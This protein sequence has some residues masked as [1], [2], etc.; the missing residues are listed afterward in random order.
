MDVVVLEGDLVVRA[1]QLDSPVMVRVATR[2]IFGSSVNVIVGQGD[3]VTG[4]LT[5][6]VVLTTQVLCCDVVDPDQ[7]GAR[8]SEGITTPDIL[9][10][11]VS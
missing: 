9:R 1:N 3:P 4:G 11:P 7:I 10:V 5:K 6:D 8:E 2:R